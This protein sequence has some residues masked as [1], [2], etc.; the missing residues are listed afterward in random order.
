MSS[1]L[2]LTTVS[3]GLGVAASHR[4]G[5]LM[6]AGKIKLAKQAARAPY[7]LSIF[8]GVAEAIV[9]MAFRHRYG[10]LFTK[11]ESVIETTAYVLPLL[12]CFQYLDLANGG[13]GGILRGLGM[14]HISGMCNF[15][16]YYGIGLTTAWWLC[17]RL[18]YGL[19]GLWFG[20]II[21]SFALLV[22]QTSCLLW[23]R[24]TAIDM[25]L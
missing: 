9:I 13:A 7:V 17:F 16:A 5:N 18:E 25:A 22:L 24:W 23:V 11:D 20:I 10:S 3:L 2:I 8:I 14:S 19:F 1:D 6:G 15:V 21:G 12:A 4:I